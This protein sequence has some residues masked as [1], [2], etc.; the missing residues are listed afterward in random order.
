MKVLWFEVTEP[1]RYKEGGKPIGGWQDSLENIVRKYSKIELCIAFMSCHSETKEIDGVTYKPIKF[2]YSFLEKYTKKYWDIFVEKMLP[3]AIKIIEDY[4]PDIIHI[5]GTEWPFGQ[6]AKYTKVPIVIHIMGAI[7]PLNNA[8]YPPG[9]SKFDIIKQ[10][11]FN[12]WKIFTTIK[13]FID[14]NNREYWERNTWHSVSNFMGRTDWD[15]MISG[16]LHPDRKYFHVE[17]ALRPSFINSKIKW[18][19]QNKTKIKLITTGCGNFWKGPDMLLKTAKIL[20][21]LNVNFEW[22]VAGKMPDNIRTIVEKKEKAKFSN[23]NVIFLGFVNPEKL[24]ELLV[25]S[26]LYV[27]T[28]Y[29]ENSPNSICEAQC[30]GVPVVST[31]VGGISTLVRNDIDGIL[32]PA[33]DPWQMTNAILE[34]STDQARLM[35]YSNN[36]REYAMSRHNPEHI[37]NQLLNCYKTIID[38]Q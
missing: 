37:L 8:N 17:E 38:N 13:T 12:L 21:E 24:S 29:M 10:C 25:S 6:I 9:Y 27:H 11:G 30:L 7:V 34:L 14:S 19:N 4:N 35:R 3:S 33:N 32:V 26:T 2:H 16:L 18:T 15:L 20:T 36:A 23:N 22:N 31:N 5:F 28:S 1:S